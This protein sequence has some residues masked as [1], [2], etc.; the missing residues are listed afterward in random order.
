MQIDYTGLPKHMR[1]GAHLYIEHGVEPGGF[2]RA[3]LSNQLVE[4][5]GRADET[6]RVAMFGWAMWLYNEC[7]RDAWGSPAKV[8]AWIEARRADRHG[9]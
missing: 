8:D 3:V 4:A 5:F 1:D 2:L 6:N 7:P 9:E